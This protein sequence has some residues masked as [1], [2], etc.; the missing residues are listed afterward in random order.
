V[1]IKTI[2]SS[3]R[4]TILA[5]LS[6][7]AACH[8]EQAKSEPARAASQRSAGQSEP[9][10]ARPP[11]NEKSRRELEVAQQKE[12]ELKLEAFFSKDAQVGGGGREAEAMIRARLTE[13]QP[14]LPGVK[15]D[16][17]VCRATMCKI[18][19]GYPSEEVRSEVQGVLVGPGAN[20]VHLLSQRSGRSMDT[21]GEVAPLR[22]ACLADSKGRVK[23]LGART[24]EHK[25]S[26]AEQRR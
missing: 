21:A 22:L 12:H 6:C 3:Q 13:S 19:M 2:Q 10:A 17:V 14:K 24:L 20:S 1:T 4:V 5:L 15:L 11:T 18:V 9:D 8:G 16:L 25:D 23:G 7:C 26:G